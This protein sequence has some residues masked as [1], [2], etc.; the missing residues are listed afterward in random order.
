M[1]G[2][3]PG[4]LHCASFH[5][6]TPPA[7][8]AIAAVF[9]ARAS[10]ETASSI[11]VAP[12]SAELL[13]AF[14]WPKY[15]AGIA[16]DYTHLNP[17]RLGPRCLYG[18]LFDRLIHRKC[19]LSRDRSNHVLELALV[20]VLVVLGMVAVLLAAASVTSHGLEM[21][22]GRRTDPDAC[23]GGWNHRITDFDSEVSSFPPN[24]STR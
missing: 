15:L 10:P 14:G 8:L 2:C 17:F 22:E 6:L 3:R 13:A 1:R 9:A 5:F 11:P 16:V 4:E 23:P 18:D 21:P 7:R 19:R 20:P 12:F 24:P